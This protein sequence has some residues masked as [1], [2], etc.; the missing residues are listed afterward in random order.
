VV[1]LSVIVPAYN[2]EPNIPR[3][4]ESVEAALR[5][6]DHELII[7]DD[8]S[9]DKTAEVASRYAEKYP[10]KVVRHDKNRGKMAAV[11]T[12][13]AHAAGQYLAFLDADLEYPPDPLPEMLRLA[14][15]GHDLV[16]AARRD[17]RPIHRR[18]VSTGA[19]WLAKILIPKLRKLKDPTTELLVVRREMVAPTDIKPHYIKPYLPLIL[20]AKQIA[21]VTVN[22]GTRTAGRSTFKLKWIPRYIRELGEL[23][24]WFTVKYIAAALA[25]GIVAG[26]LSPYLGLWAVAVSILGRWGLL[27]KYI[28][29]PQIAAAELA[30]IAVKYALAFIPAIWFVKAAVELLLIHLLR[31]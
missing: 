9:T 18:V 3:L 1:L 17:P 21:E 11:A 15:Q 23:T 22:L 25:V 6:V 14:Q 20:K 24:D 16:L 5:G 4:V 27:R 19:R 30:S 13:I 8:G 26:L 29:L 12:G 10:V 28:G 31:R 7:V 2:E